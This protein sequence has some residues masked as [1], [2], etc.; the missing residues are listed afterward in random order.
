MGIT[1]PLNLMGQVVRYAVEVF[2]LKSNLGSTVLVPGPQRCWQL[3]CL[4][5]GTPGSQGAGIL[6]SPEVATS[7]SGTPGLP[8]FPPLQNIL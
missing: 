3:P 8:T 7:T 6:S 2:F 5:R 4:G 1:G